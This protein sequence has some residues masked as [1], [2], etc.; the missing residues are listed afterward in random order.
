VFVWNFW[1]EVCISGLQM[2]AQTASVVSASPT[3]S[4]RYTAS[5]PVITNDFNEAAS[6]GAQVA[7]E[8]QLASDA[9]VLA[10]RMQENERFV[11]HNPVVMGYSLS[12]AL[13]A[14][15]G[16]ASMQWMQDAQVA[17]CSIAIRGT[18]DSLSA[19]WDVVVGL[20]A[21]DCMQDGL[22][23]ALHP[24]Y[25]HALLEKLDMI[26]EGME[27]QAAFGIF[28]TRLRC[29]I[30]NCEGGWR[31]FDV[32]L[33]AEPRFGQAHCRAM[34]WDVHEQV[35]TEKEL[36]TAHIEAELAQRGRYEFLGH[37][38][39]ELRTP[40]N[41]MLGF[42][43]MMEQGVM[44]PIENPYYKEYLANIRESGNLLLHRISDM[45]EIVNIE[46]GVVAVEDEQVQLNDWLQS[47]IRL[48]QHEAAN[49][50]IQVVL[51]GPVP[52]MLVYGDRVKLVRALGNIISNAVRFS[53]PEMQVRLAC[54]KNMHGG[55][56]V[57]VHDT[58]M[59]MSDNHLS[60]LRSA[61]SERYCLFQHSPEAVSVGLGLAVAKEF[62]EL[63][64]GDLRI[65]SVKDA[66][67]SVYIGLPTARVVSLETP[68]TSA[69]RKEALA[70]S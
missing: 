51:D 17:S 63:H 57:A 40:L 26:F 60:M 41:A 54:I 1:R 53:A 18:I 48:H 12:E 56:T 10:A 58:G 23:M 47:A 67:T 9:V 65:D 45:V 52:R 32:K 21:D 4:S 28:S 30:A 69:R 66:G 15:T 19:N 36:R 61:L 34:F 6:L 64:E 42:A 5:S 33:I 8:N 7:C 43:E 49:R 24:Y 39:H 50:H 70:A 35:M 37:M 2:A 22:M 20:S 44:G 59:G 62:L 68:V 14:I 27:E 46:V 55:I 11:M 29:Q 3:A 13:C 25:R 38:S 16:G 31:W